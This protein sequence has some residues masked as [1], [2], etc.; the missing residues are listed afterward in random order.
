MD[1]T[2][3]WLLDLWEKNICPQCGKVIP[4]G[5]RIGSGRKSEGG[6]CSLDCYAKFYE[7]ELVERAKRVQRFFNPPF[8]TAEEQ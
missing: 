3:K 5:A 2:T 6:F 4:E 7:A 8:G 1:A